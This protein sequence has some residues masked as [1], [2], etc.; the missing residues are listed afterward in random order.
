MSAETPISADLLKGHRARIRAR[1]EKDP[2]GVAD[3][4]VMELLL[5]LSITRKDT[6]LLAK[7]LLNRFGGFRAALDATPEE[8]MEVP[9]FGDGLAKLWLLIREV[10]V[11]YNA[12][13]YLERKKICSP[14]DLA[15]MGQMR[16]GNLSHEECWIALVNTQNALLVWDRLKVGNINTIGIEPRE[17]LERGIRAKASG[18]ILVHNH[19][20]GN[21]T[22]S[23]ADLELT[24]ELT[25]LCPRLGLRLLDHIVVTSGVCYSIIM[26]KILQTNGGQCA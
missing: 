13:P 20:G 25:E 16:L 15:A 6:K 7:E 9:G 17:I 8:L 14:L 12:A 18:V 10:M 24:K 3:Y 26:K 11:R 4:E 2:Y 1:L 22:P 23:S 5:G 21:P 19:P